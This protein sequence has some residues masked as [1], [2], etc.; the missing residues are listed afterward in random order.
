MAAAC[1]AVSGVIS[2]RA[3]VRSAARPSMEV[4]TSSGAWAVAAYSS[5]WACAGPSCQ[6]RR[7]TSSFTVST[8]RTFASG[9]PAA[10]AAAREAAP[11]R[12]SR[13]WTT[14]TIA[15][16]LLPTYS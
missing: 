8:A 5:S 13:D 15:S 6:S 10:S 1:R 2:D 9:V 3:E 4:A 11:A 16:S 7:A 12:S 14:L